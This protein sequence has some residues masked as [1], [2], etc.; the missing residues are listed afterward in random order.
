MSDDRPIEDQKP[1]ALGTVY[2]GTGVSPGIAIGPA[3]LV[4][5][6]LGDL[7]RYHLPEEDRE[8]EC[9]RFSEAVRIAIGQLEGI[10]ARTESIPG[11]GGRDVGQLLDAHLAMLRNSRLI[12]G[13]D[14][15]IRDEG[16]NAEAAV[17]A[18]TA[19]IRAR[20][21]A[22]DD[23]YLA[24]RIQDIRDVAG[25]LIRALTGQRYRAFGNLPVGSIIIADEITPA[26]TALMHPEQVAAF[27]TLTGGAQGHTAI[28]A[29]SLGIPAVLG[30]DG[31]SSGVVSGDTVIV[32][33]S[34]G[35]IIVNPPADILARYRDSQSLDRR[36]RNRLRSLIGVPARSRDGSDMALM[37]NI[38]LPWEVESVGSLDADGVGLLRTEFLFM[39][40]DD[41]P[42]EEE[43]T[44][45]LKTIVEGAAGRPVTIRT[46]D[47]GGEKLVRAL[48]RPG[49]PSP[50][51][52]LGLR[53][54][55]L[56]LR[57]SGL[58]TSQLSAILR[59]A[60]LG[61]VRILLPMVTS[62]DE[63]ADVRKALHRCHA[64]LKSAGVP[65]PDAPPPLGAM[66]EVP[67][68]A[69]TADLLA[70]C[71]DFLALG[72]NDLTQ[73][74]LA[75]DRADDAVAA[76]YDPLHPAV[77]RLISMVAEA[78]EKESCPLSLCGEMAGDPRM[79]PLLV[80]M[81]L[82]TL[83]MAPGNLL[84][85]KER[86]LSLDVPSARRRAADIMAQTDRGRI[87]MLLDDFNDALLR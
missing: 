67:A 19:A 50:N 35:K 20:F 87:A 46:L 37:I 6:G 42:G 11:E 59:A 31:L 54:V 8:T 41:I 1:V 38:E 70:R 82:T 15:R 5:T 76:L 45:V 17:Q 36:A 65:V 52:A 53:A 69:V 29:R 55:R 62:P 12:R 7:P 30:A 48:G 26:D 44:A 18:E 4:E 64:A 83:S 3:H 78:A 61:P 23:P 79:L 68:A 81:G 25:R 57:H 39:N 56:S 49:T 28:M 13:V 43:Q 85:V 34:A 77:L 74:T 40:R 16:L 33:G 66:I 84:P 10:R 27:A 9:G 60:A 58:L 14:R 24:A 75:A 63:V 80:G 47:A 21:E 73:Y 51:P 72:T 22:L 71:C 86:L 2:S 32:D